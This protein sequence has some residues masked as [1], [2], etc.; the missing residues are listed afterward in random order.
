MISSVDGFAGKWKMLALMCSIKSTCS[1]IATVKFTPSFNGYKYGACSVLL[2]DA[3]KD[4]TMKK[5]PLL[6]NLQHLTEDIT[7]ISV[8]TAGNNTTESS[9]G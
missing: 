5:T 4:T 2:V 8:N 9:K 7:N 1:E 3:R 6:S